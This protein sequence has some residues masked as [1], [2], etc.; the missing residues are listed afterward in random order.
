MVKTIYFSYLIQTVCIETVSTGLFCS[1]DACVCVF[2]LHASINSLKAIHF[3]PTF[4]L[5]RRLSFGAFESKGLNAY[6]FLLKMSTHT[7]QGKYIL[8]KYCLSIFL[9]K[10]MFPRCVYAVRI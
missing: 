9:R 3:F 8:L 2:I 10:Q 6:F 7:R 5:P 1:G 4:T